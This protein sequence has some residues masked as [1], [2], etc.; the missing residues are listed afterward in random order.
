MK[1]LSVIVPLYNEK[2][3]VINELIKN[4]KICLSKITNNW[5]II[6]VDD[7]STNNC[8]DVILKASDNDINI[9]GIKLS[10]NFGQHC[11]IKAGIDNTKS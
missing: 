1:H 4:L 3:V 9:S 2:E 10:K 8:W 7:G 6:L 5:K 11:A